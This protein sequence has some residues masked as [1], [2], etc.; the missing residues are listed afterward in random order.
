MSE[1]DRGDYP[2]HL[3]EWLID[4]DT[5]PLD[6]G[7][8]NRQAAAGL[9]GLDL[10]AALPHTASPI[11][12]WHGPA[13]A[14]SG[15]CT[16][17]STTRTS[18]AKTSTRPP[19]VSGTGLCTGAKATSRM[20]NTGS[21]VSANIRCIHSWPL[22]PIASRRVTSQTRQVGIRLILSIAVNLPSAAGGWPLRWVKSAD[23]SGI[24]SSISAIDA[25]SARRVPRRDQAMG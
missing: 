23:A 8:P 24:C 20:P 1:F 4:E 10:D 22:K 19:A 17:S 6:A 7:S 15:C 5:L 18:S 21:A 2:D 14:A 9:R 3:A 11:A 16:I 25:R 13:T 12:K